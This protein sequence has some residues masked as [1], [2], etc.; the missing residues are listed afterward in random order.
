MKLIVAGLLCITPACMALGGAL[1]ILKTTDPGKAM[2]GI[3]MVLMALLLAPSTRKLK[4]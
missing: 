4:G 1:L 2:F 3:S